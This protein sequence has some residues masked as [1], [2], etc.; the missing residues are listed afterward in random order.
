MS[1][2][3]SRVSD[4]LDSF[5]YVY[6]EVGY[7]FGYEGAASINKLCT[8]LFNRGF[9]LLDLTLWGRSGEGDALFVKYSLISGR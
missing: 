4:E 2:K 7:G 6:T 3:F 5:S 1:L 9:E 8:Y